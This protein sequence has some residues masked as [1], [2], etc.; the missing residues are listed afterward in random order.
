MFLF[1]V[2]PVMLLIP[3]KLLVMIHL[4][5]LVT[6]FLECPEKTTQSILRF[7]NLDSAVTVKLTEVTM[8][9]LRLNVMHSTFAQLMGL[10]VWQ[11]TAS[12]VLMEHSSTRITSYA[13]GGSTLIA[14]LL[15]IST[16]SMMKLLLNVKLLREP[17]LMLLA[18]MKHLQ[19]MQ[20]VMRVLDHLRKKVAE[21]EG[22]EVQGITGEEEVVK[23]EK[24]TSEVELR[25]TTNF[26]KYFGTYT[27]DLQYYLF[28]YIVLYLFIFFVKYT[29]AY[30]DKK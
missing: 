30:N 10:E 19:N 7:L 27:Y 9:T 13:T 3:M 26:M 4:L 24:E 2:Q 21:A 12:S 25:L 14:Q 18:L 5:L 1:M 11:S 23:E 15:K 6:V 8:R 17:L 28:C 16:L 29:E 22:L 20:L